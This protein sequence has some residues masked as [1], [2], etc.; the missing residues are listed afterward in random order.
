MAMASM[1]NSGEPTP[2]SMYNTRS[3]CMLSNLIFFSRKIFSRFFLAVKRLM[4]EA[5]ELKNPT[6]LFYCQPI[7]VNI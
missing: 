7:E 2:P 3:T 1:S 5:M 6:E 4:R